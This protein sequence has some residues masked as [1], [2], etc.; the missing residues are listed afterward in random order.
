LSYREWG[1]TERWQSPVTSTAG[2]FGEQNLPLCKSDLSS[3]FALNYIQ[4]S[5]KL[6]T[7][8]LTVIVTGQQLNRLLEFVVC[9]LQ[10]VEFRLKV[11]VLFSHLGEL[12]FQISCAF[13]FS[14]AKGSLGRTILLLAPLPTISLFQGNSETLTLDV[15]GLSL[16]GLEEEELPRL[17][18]DHNSSICVS[19]GLINS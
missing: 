12:F 13:F 14:L 15:C 5:P 9:R 3:G 16:W 6:V 17:G 11:L 1:R 4:K 8:G 7:A 10:I 18:Y 19:E 2:P